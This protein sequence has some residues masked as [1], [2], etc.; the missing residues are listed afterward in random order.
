MSAFNG[1][2][3]AIFDVLMGWSVGFDLVVWPVVMGVA[4]L[5][6][7]KYV[8]NQKA[9]ARVKSRISMHLL[10]V[11]LFSHDIV[12]VLRSTGAILVQNTLYLGNHLVPMVVML[13][14]MLAV[15]AQLVAHYAYAPAPPG[16]VDLLRVELDPEAPRD[17]SLELPAGV[18]LDAPPV[19]TP[20]GRVFWR[21]RAE[22]E[23][24]HVLRVRVGGDAFE[25]SWA[26]GGEPRK[27]PLKR[28]RGL[29]AVLYPGEAALPAAAPLRS[30]E[31]GVHPR[32]LRFLPDGE[33][34]IVLWF[35]ALSLVA[36]FALRG[37]FGVT[38]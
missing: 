35:L 8:S 17:V 36:G 6:I 32:A 33:L 38:F 11:R 29:E 14:P 5:Q 4:A 1:L 21:L 34:G 37:L 20:D 27:I 13:V 3:N 15:M 16:S 12:Q 31:L 9:L 7:Y 30:L 28:L 10:E 18:A 2:S 24:D 26:V 25:K 22:G 19:R 23:G